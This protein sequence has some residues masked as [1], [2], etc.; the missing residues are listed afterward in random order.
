MKKVT[1]FIKKHSKLVYILLALGVVTFVFVMFPS[2]KT[3]RVYKKLQKQYSELMNRKVEEQDQLE[4]IRKEQ[5]KRNKEINE[6]Y[7]ETIRHIQENHD[8]KLKEINEQQEENIRN[9]VSSTNG[10][11]E[12]MAELTSKH[13]DIP[14]YQQQITKLPLPNQKK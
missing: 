3:G 1:D 12:K 2:M 10:N 13:W 14:V 8:S 5:Q 7:E 9:I 11:P 4:S 6:R